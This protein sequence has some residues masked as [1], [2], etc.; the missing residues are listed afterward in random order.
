MAKLYFT[1]SPMNSGKSMMLIASAHS[2][3]ERNIPFLCLKP[4]IDNRNGENVIHSRALGD[5]ECI[6][7]HHDTNIYEAINKLIEFA[8]ISDLQTLKWILI[9]EAQFLTEEH[10][11]QLA[12]IVDEFNINVKCYGLRTDFRTRLFPGSKRLF[13]LADTIEEIKS[14]CHCGNKNIVNVRLNEVGEV[15]TEGEQVLLGS[16]DKYTTACRKCYYEAINK[17]K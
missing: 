2:F 15:V 16:E 12:K 8:N 13:E 5:K 9:D 11:E 10:V 4:S 14:S 6:V 3:K 7:I 17:N 1:Y